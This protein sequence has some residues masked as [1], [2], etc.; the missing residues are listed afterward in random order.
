MMFAIA[1]PLLN[2]KLLFS[3]DGTAIWST[4]DNA[5]GNVIGRPIL[6]QRVES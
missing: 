3:R 4:V 6:E 5:M 2:H 1:A